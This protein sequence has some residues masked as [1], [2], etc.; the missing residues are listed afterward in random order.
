VTLGQQDGKIVVTASRAA[1]YSGNDRSAAI[2][3]ELFEYL[4]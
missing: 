3:S 4:Y 2:L 1:D